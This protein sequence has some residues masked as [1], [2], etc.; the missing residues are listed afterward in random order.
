M[1]ARISHNRLNSMGLHNRGFCPACGASI[2]A[3]RHLATGAICE[4][5]WYDTSHSYQNDQLSQKS[6]IAVM[7]FISTFMAIGFVH[8][9]NWGG[10]W[11][12]APLLQAQRLTG[13]LS[14]SGFEQLT[15]ICLN[16]GKVN[17]AEVV[18]H[19][20]MKAAGN[21]ESI[22]DHASLLTRI[23]KID[24]SLPFFDMYFKN[25]GKN[26][27]TAAKYAKL[28]ED[29]GQDA[30]ALQFYELSVQS[31][32][33]GLLPIL[34]T[35]GVVRILY[36]MGQYQQ[37]FDRITT[38]HAMSTNAIGYLNA[39]LALVE[40]AIETTQTTKTSQN[41]KKTPKTKTT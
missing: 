18:S 25:A 17:C 26:P 9:S 30:L 39:E 38:F 21:V 16:L 37:A 36:K 5:G 31:T 3:E 28:L 27:T 41:S 11:L 22:A 33:A 4:C 19:Q 13:T 12:T 6:S 1:F 40:K 10:Y 23:G 29:R 34:G 8:L 14:P 7:L 35:S 2:S 32:Q 15:K 24:A 20:K